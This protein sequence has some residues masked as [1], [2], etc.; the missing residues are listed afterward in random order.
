MV[1]G[2]DREDIPARGRR[3]AR[4]AVLLLACLTGL[5]GCQSARCPATGLAARE[6]VV[7]GTPTAEP[8]RAGEEPVTIVRIGAP[9][10]RPAAFPKDEPRQEERRTNDK[11]IVE[12][13]GPAAVGDIPPS[14]EQFIDLATALAQAGMENPTIARAVEVVRGAQAELLGARALLLP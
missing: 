10:V 12:V 7:P 6:D 9:V 1:R 4:R 13:A 3:R 11:N 2:C 8:S 5:S 14:P